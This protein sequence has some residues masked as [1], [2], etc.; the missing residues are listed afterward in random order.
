MPAAI[1]SFA[2]DDPVP[3]P[4]KAKWQHSL[5]LAALM[6]DVLAAHDDP[7]GVP[8]YPSSYTLVA[9]RWDDALAELGDGADWIPLP[10]PGAGIPDLGALLE[11]PGADLEVFVNRGDGNFERADGPG[12]SGW[13]TGLATGDVDGDGDAD[14][15]AGGYGGLRVL[16][17]D[18]DGT[19][20]PSAAGDLLRPM[21]THVPLLLL[22]CS[23]PARA[24]AWRA[25]T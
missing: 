13:W 5:R 11:G 4:E 20:V 8:I 23:R 12:L 17:Q 6:G 18:A 25:F 21:R 16:L 3:M 2:L 24:S 7:R 14:L 1:S 9:T 22:A 19:L 15:V 10:A